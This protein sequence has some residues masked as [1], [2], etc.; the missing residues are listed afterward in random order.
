MSGKSKSCGCIKSFGEKKIASILRKNKINFK[1]EFTFKDCKTEN[2]YLCR[3][4]FAIFNKDNKLKCLIE[5]D[6]K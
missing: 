2:G 5:Y 1:Q 3:F 6:G 4:D